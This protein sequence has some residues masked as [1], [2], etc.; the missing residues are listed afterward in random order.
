MVEKIEHF[1]HLSDENKEILD[2][3]LKISGD[4]MVRLKDSVKKY[5]T[6]YTLADIEKEFDDELLDIVGWPLLMAARMRKVMAFKLAHLNGEYL[7]KFLAYNDDT[8]L[9][10]LRSEIDKELLSRRSKL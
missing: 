9:V 8:Y 1:E 3:A 5:G 10:M 2:E 7:Q 6:A 4:V